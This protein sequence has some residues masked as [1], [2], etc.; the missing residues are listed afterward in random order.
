[1]DEFCF[2]IA[3]LVLDQFICVSSVL[4]ISSSY[5]YSVWEEQV[6]DGST[7]SQEF[8]HRYNSITLVWVF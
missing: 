1:M 6:V 2:K 7:L 3:I 5:Y 4:V 8:R